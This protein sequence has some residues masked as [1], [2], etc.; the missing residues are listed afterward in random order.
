MELD[1][2]TAIG[3][4][5]TGLVSL[6][7]WLLKRQQT[8]LD[9]QETRLRAEFAEKL[10]TERQES[11]ESRARERKYW[12]EK[13]D[14][15][16]RDGMETQALNRLIFQQVLAKLKIGTTLHPPHEPQPSD[17]YRTALPTRNE[18]EP[19]GNES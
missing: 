10:A 5:F 2:T 9:K 3:G 19:S 13:F 15:I 16:T 14:T 1:A 8:L 11:T 12:L 6:I 4:A 17:E 18:R 7:G